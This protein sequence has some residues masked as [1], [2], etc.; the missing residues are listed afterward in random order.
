M[1]KF[2]RQHISNFQWSMLNDA[3]K[4]RLCPNVLPSLSDTTKETW[5]SAYRSVTIGHMI[6]FLCGKEM[7]TVNCVIDC[8]DSMGGVEIYDLCDLLFKDCLEK[9]NEKMTKFKIRLIKS[10]EQIEI[11]DRVRMICIS[12]FKIR[13]IKS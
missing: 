2:V 5:K 9:L 3:Q 10:D 11:S 6:D 1:T 12:G 8:L 13:K 4:F 7:Y